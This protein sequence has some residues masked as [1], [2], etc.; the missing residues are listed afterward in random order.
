[1]GR[2]RQ[3]H[4]WK[5]RQKVDVIIDKKEEKKVGDNERIHYNVLM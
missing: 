4:N 1:M 5:A 3:R 2:T